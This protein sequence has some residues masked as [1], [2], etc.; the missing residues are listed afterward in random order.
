MA[1]RFTRGV[2]RGA[3]RQTS[4]FDI[5]PVSV[6]HTA[7]SAIL[8]ASLTSA[9]KARRPF[10]IVRTHLAFQFGTDQLIA[11]E[12]FGLGIGMC[13]VSDQAAAVGVSAV[14]T[15]ITD[16][17]SD[18]WFIHQIAMGELLFGSGI[19][20]IEDAGPATTV[21]IDSKVMRKVNDDQ[22]IILVSEGLGLDSGFGLTVAGRLLIK[23]H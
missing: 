15:P 1:R 11:S 10:T 12:T 4:W 6:V 9:E 7:G 21:L 23:E 13:V 5:V 16:L 22:D 18:L 8:L 20:F 14:P 19:G 2:N 17:A 3:K